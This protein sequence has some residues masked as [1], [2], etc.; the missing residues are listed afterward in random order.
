MRLYQ[1]E[2]ECATIYG[3]HEIVKELLSDPRVD[4]SDC[5][6][7][8]IRWASNNGHLDVVKLLLNDPRTKI[9][10]ESIND[11]I[12]KC[13]YDNVKEILMHYKNGDV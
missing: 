5:R 7:K 2:F 11:L 9:S 3:H 13:E 4:P 10:F 6:N 8:A 12:G 1:H